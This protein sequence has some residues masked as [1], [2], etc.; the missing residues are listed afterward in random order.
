MA[1]A[2]SPVTRIREV[3]E[4]EGHEIFREIAEEVQTGQHRVD[5]VN[6]IAEVAE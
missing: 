1:R 2:H 4:G 3:V 6:D 5:V